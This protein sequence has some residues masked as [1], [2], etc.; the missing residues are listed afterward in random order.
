MKRTLDSNNDER[1]RRF[2]KWLDDENVI[3]NNVLIRQSSLGKGYALY[4]NFSDDLPKIEIPTTLLMTIDAAKRC[5]TF[6]VPKDEILEKTDDHIDRESLILSLFLLHELSRGEESRWSP[7]I[8]LLPSTFASPLF[9]KEN[10]VE[11]TTAFHLGETMKN[12]LNEVFQMID[13]KNFSLNDFLWA[14]LIVGSRAF[15]LNEFGTVLIPFAD[16]ANHVSLKSEANLRSSGVD[17]QTNRFVLIPIEEN[18]VKGDELNLQYNELANWQLLLNFGFAIENNPFD[19][20]FIELQFDSNESNE[21]EMKKS[22]LIN[23]CE[24]FSFEHELKL[25]DDESILSDD[26]LGTLRLIVMTSDELENYS[27]S[28]LDEILSNSINDENERRA[29]KKLENILNEFQEKNFTTTLEENQQRLK[30]TNLNDDERNA[31]IYLVGQKEIV[32]RALK[33]IE[34]KVSIL[35]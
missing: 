28:N 8:E 18:L 31:L 33:S 5:S 27:I 14:F 15:K 11:M 30:S 9:H 7:Y 6:V 21:I 25:R 20:I 16:L 35:K 29:L 4:K 10:L 1:L 32:D 3:R 22:F 17:F 13:L 19:S 12:S 23:L 2:E 24:N 34:E 26:L